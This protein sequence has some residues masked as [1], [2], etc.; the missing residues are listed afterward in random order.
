MESREWPYGEGD[1]VVSREDLKT[2]LMHARDGWPKSGIGRDALT[3][4]EYALGHRQVYINLF[5]L[6]NERLAPSVSYKTVEEALA[7]QNA[8]SFVQMITVMVPR[9]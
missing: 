1:V 5:R 8:T 4:C 6:D 3:R 9:E 2:V 7:Q